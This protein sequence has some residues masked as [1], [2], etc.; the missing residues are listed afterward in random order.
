MVIGL[1][2]GAMGPLSNAPIDTISKLP[3]TPNVPDVFLL[4]FCFPL[5]SLYGY[6]IPPLPGRLKG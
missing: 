1:V 3:S 5:Q 6:N 2:S 4:L